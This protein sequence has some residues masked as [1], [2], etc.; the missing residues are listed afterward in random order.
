M[1]LVIVINKVLP[2]T[3]PPIIGYQFFAYQLAVIC[4]ADDHEPWLYSHFI[5]LIC[6]PSDPIVAFYDEYVWYETNPWFK[7]EKLSYKTIDTLNLNLLE[8]II[9]YIENDFYVLAIIDE[10]YLPNRKSYHKEHFIHDLLIYGYDRENNT[11]NTIGFDENGIF[12]PQKL[13]FNDFQNA[14]CNLN[15]YMIFFSLIKEYKYNFRIDII[16]NLLSDYLYSKNTSARVDCL[17]ERRFL[18]GHVFGLNIYSHLQNYFRFLLDG[19]R[20]SDIRSLHFLY[21]HKEMMISRIKFLIDRGH[22]TDNSNVFIEGFQKLRDK[23]LI[24]RSLQLKFE[25]S[26]RSREIKQIINLIQDI[27]EEERRLLESLLNMLK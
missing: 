1:E 3:N 11:Y 4:I 24:A 19:K 6:N 21:E 15:N 25:V 20:L 13:D 9:N 7:F 12:R 5:Q 2:I 10:F 27:Y 17:D 14:F 18:P 8:L 23:T 26:K 16:K 22:L